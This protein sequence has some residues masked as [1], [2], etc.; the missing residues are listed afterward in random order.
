MDVQ[1]LLS[2]AQ[3][4]VQAQLSNSM[5]R[6]I[7]EGISTDK[8]LYGVLKGGVFLNDQFV[9]AERSEDEIKAA[10][11]VVAR[12]RLL[13]AVWKATN[14]FIIRGYKPCTQDGPNGALPDDDVFSYCSPDGIMMNVVQSHRGKLLQKF[15]SAHLLSP[16]YNL[17]TQYFV[18][19]SW[20]CQD[21]YG[22]YNY[23]PYKGKALPANPDA[24]CIVSLAVCDMTRKDI[25]KMAKKKGIVKACREVGGLPKI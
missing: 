1:Y 14:H 2:K 13:A 17:T 16:K 23:D 9:T 15:P 4:Q 19:Q 5:N 22:S 21:K 3:K 10:I 7:S 25:Q 6:T 24:E 20:N 12:A 11:S 18:E 8:G